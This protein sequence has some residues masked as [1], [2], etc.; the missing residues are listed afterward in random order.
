MNRYVLALLIAVISGCATTGTPMTSGNDDVQMPNYSLVVPPNKG[1]HLSKPDDRFQVALLTKSVDA[2]VFLIRFVR[3]P[4]LDQRMKSAPARV[5]ADDFRNLERQIMLKEGVAKGQYQLIGLVMDE[6][7]F[8][9]NKLYT[10]TYTIVNG[11]RDQWAKLLLYF[12]KEANNE[13]FILAHYSESGPGGAPTDMR[14][15]RAELGEILS[16]LRVKP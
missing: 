14:P 5:V 11:P 13:Y 1:W 10:M 4:I 8:G 7:T 6:E 15:Q 2:S 3:V 12:P 9:N 16:S